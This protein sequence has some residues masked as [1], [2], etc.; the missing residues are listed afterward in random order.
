[1]GE[2]H[3]F[4][5]LRRKRAEI[6]AVITAYEAKI[7]AAKVDLAALDKTLLLFEP[8]AARQVSAYFELEQTPIKLHCSRERRLVLCVRQV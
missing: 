8:G 4:T 3:I 6:E 1:M 5:I 7:D 2:P